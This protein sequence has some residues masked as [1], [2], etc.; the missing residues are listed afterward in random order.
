MFLKSLEIHGFKSFAQKTVLDFGAPQ[1]SKHSVTAVVGPNGSGKSNISD[2]I[3]WV[4]GEQ[5]MK[6][7]RGKKGEDIIFSGSESKGQMG[8]ASVSL[9]LDNADGR[10]DVDYEELV[11]TRRYYRNGDSE[12]LINGAPVR[13]F[14][15]QLLLAKAQFGQGSYS[16]IGQGMID[17]LLLQ[18]P[19]ERKDFFDEASGIKEFQI[20]RHQ[21]ALKLAR[22]K[23]NT[24]QAELLLQEI[25]PRL[26]TLSRQVKKLEQRQEVEIELREAQESYFATINNHNQAQLDEITAG[27]VQ[28]N[29]EYN[30][31]NE[32]LTAVQTE[33]AN[34]ARE[35]S[36]QEQFG[37]LQR[38]YQE[39]Q[40]RKNNLERES[41]VLSGKLQT[42]YSKVGKQNLGW[43]ENKIKD[44]KLDKE[45]LDKDL[46]DAENLSDG[47]VENILKQK[48]F[49]EDIVF[50]RTEAKSQLAG[51]EQKITQ[52]KSEQS[53][54]QFSGLKAVQAVLEE[55]QR[56]GNIYG[57]VAQLGEVQEK[58]RLALDVAASSHLSSLIT[59]SD[60]TAQAGIE[61]LRSHQL[62]VATFLPLNKIKPRLVSQDIEELQKFPGVHGL[63][64]KLIKFDARFADIFSYV[65]GNTLIVENL[66]TA[67]EIGIGRVRM[68]TLTGDILETSGT[69]KGG[70]RQVDKRRGLSFSH[71]D[72]PYLMQEEIMNQ[73]EKIADWQ[74]KL[75]ELENS[76]EKAQEELRSLQTEAQI[77]TSRAQMFAGQ[78]QAVDKELAGFEQELKYN[79]MSPEEYTASLKEITGQKNDLEKQIKILDKELSDVEELII[80][81]N[82]SEEAKKQRIFALQ[83]LVQEEQQKLNKIVDERNSKQV[84]IAKLE[85]KQEDLSNEVYQEMQ[86]ALSAVLAR[87]PKILDTAEIDLTQQKI[88]KLKYQLSLIGGIEEEAVQEYQETKTRYENLSTQLKD[89]KAAM[90]DLE[91]M[92]AELDE[93]MKKKRDKAFKQI[94]KEFARYFELLFEGGKADLIELYGEVQDTEGT[95][96]MENTENLENISGE[97]PSAPLRSVQGKQMLVGIDVTACPPGKKIKNIQALSGGERTMTSIALVC[98]ILHTNPSPFVVLDEVE[99]ALD[100]ANTLRF[101]KILQELVLQSQFVLITHNRATMHAADALYGVTMGVDGVSKLL[102]VK[103]SEAEQVSE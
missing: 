92:V 80:E 21:A 47:A 79:N 13:L 62:G 16:V 35:G 57:T 74:N 26:R 20:K 30:K 45:K 103:L 27:L 59:D 102:S 1:N 52:V 63:A 15:L 81:F 87:G 4:M 33:L 89:L 95:E 98:A 48:K 78:K 17:R 61:Y 72:S 90:E 34:L 82:Q 101:T 64:V 76:F 14:D 58:Y 50:S 94:K 36:R 70:F 37:E 9:T 54:W 71:G 75:A 49:I 32:K 96:E 18:T 77:A 19:Q 38:A 41:A 42:E 46:G 7:L 24:A 11:I 29:N 53:Y 23:E 66:D 93:V 67:R 5:S 68:V 2:A 6:A 25:E 22:T 43:L 12:Y 60:R 10:A 84:A 40:H 99:A 51:I 91:V 69:M 86:T 65:L 83:E 3:R 56:L 85:T 55:R 8:M 97:N 100:E 39:I 88:Q 31:V 28:V 73:E 44:L